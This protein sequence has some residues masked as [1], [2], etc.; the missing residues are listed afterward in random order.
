MP[1]KDHF[2]PFLP[3][4]QYAWPSLPADDRVR[5]IFERLKS[6]ILWSGKSDKPVVADDMLKDA[7][8]NRLDAIAA[9]P[10]CGPLLDE[11][12]ATLS[13]WLSSS[14]LADRIQL[15]VLPPCD[16]N[17]IIEAW[18]GRHD[19]ECLIPPARKDLRPLSEPQLPDVDGNGVLVIPRLEDWFIRHRNGLGTVRALMEALSASDR[20]F[21]VGCNSW[22]WAYLTVAI[23][24]Q[25]QLPNGCTFQAFDS[26]RLFDWFSKL[27]ADPASGISKFRKPDSGMDVFALDE[28][29]AP[30]SDFFQKLAAHS[31][32]IPWVAW[33]LWRRSLRTNREDVD[34][35]VADDDDETL[36]IA[37]LDDFSLPAEHRQEALLVLQSLLVHGRLSAESLRLTVPFVGRSNVVQ[38]LIHGGFVKL[39]AELLT[40]VA[41]AYPAIRRELLDAGFSM[42][43]L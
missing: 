21:V 10:A 11:L 2:A 23:N 34:D 4:G 22:A 26:Q 1:T 43:R 18:A 6:E 41:A 14:G 30:K 42:D 32:G 37:A 12:G 35:K 8:V 9:P 24:A 19:L 17:K 39:E 27:S 5:L 38:A 28:N 36:W 33:N 3:L 7:T 40:C 25:M 16:E 15:I 13:A 29:G 31:L 20:R